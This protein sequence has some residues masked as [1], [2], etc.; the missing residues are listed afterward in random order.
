MTRPIPTSYYYSGQGRLLIGERNSTGGGVNFVPVGNV[1]SLT[2]DIA[3]TKF[4]HKESMSGVRATDATI[5]TEQKA[6]VKFS[7]ESL[8]I[9]NLVLGLYGETSTT[10]STAVVAEPHVYT[11]GGA[12][13]LKNPAVSALTISTGTTQTVVYCH[14]TAGGTGYTSAP[15]V[16]FT[17]GAGTGA[18]AT[19]V[20]TDGVVTSI[21]ITNAGTGYTS[22]P[23]IGFTGGAGTGAAATAYVGAVPALTTDYTLDADFGTIYP[24]ST[25][26]KIID[27]MTI[28]VSYTAGVVSRVDALTSGTAPERFLRFEG[29]N[30]YNGDLVLLE[31][32]RTAIDPITGL[33]YINENFG[34]ADFTGNILLDS[35]ITS[36]SQ[37]FV[38]RT[39][40][41]A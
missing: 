25:S 9:A 18:A 32:P 30:T 33:E 35:L 40:T 20:L 10:T 37:F 38:Q 29:L 5:I 27:G 4:E 8:N 13:A 26:T 36:G 2:V 15:T 41:P 28:L 21:T 24:V 19:A 3:V 7:T 12:I 16:G 14:V 39:I 34:K 11:A 22:A 1:T 23:T 17:G 6:T 31:L